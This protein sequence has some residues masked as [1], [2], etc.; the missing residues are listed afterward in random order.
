MQNRL[1]AAV[2]PFNG[3]ARSG[4]K[5]AHGR[6]SAGH[7]QLQIPS[8]AAASRNVVSH[9]CRQRYFDTLTDVRLLNEDTISLLASYGADRAEQAILIVDQSDRHGKAKVSLLHRYENGWRCC[10]HPRHSRHRRGKTQHG[11]LFAVR[12]RCRVPSRI[13]GGADVQYR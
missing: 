7:R 13:S 12:L 1:F 9:D 6:Q 5:P 8:R 11:G 4:A 3:N 2:I 10:Q